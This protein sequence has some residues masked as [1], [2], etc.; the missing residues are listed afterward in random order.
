M[1][2]IE[3]RS[4]DQFVRIISEKR[5]RA[6]QS[7]RPFFSRE[8]EGEENGLCV[9]MNESS[10]QIETNDEFID[11]ILI[12]NGQRSIQC[13]HLNNGEEVFLFGFVFLSLD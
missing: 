11:G 1:N 6:K 12:E 2:E 13:V 3:E 5:S 8:R 4:T 10:L 9:D 7:H